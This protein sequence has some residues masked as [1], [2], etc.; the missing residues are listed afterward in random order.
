MAVVEGTSIKKL[1]VETKTVAEEV[2]TTVG[3]VPWN[4]A[5][6]PMAESSSYGGETYPTLLGTRFPQG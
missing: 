6:N 3:I 1:L 2:Q 5:D 4:I